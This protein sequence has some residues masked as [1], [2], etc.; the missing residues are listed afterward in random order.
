[1]AANDSVGGPVPGRGGKAGAVPPPQ[2]NLKAA[3]DRAVEALR[4][5]SPEQMLWLGAAG[6]PDA[7]RLPVLDD[8][9][10][11]DIDGGAVRTSGG[12]DVGA[13]WR[14]LVL[15]YL[16]ISTRPQPRQPETTF[17]ALPDAMTYAGVYD[18][19][20]I[21]RL[22]ATAGRDA[23]S[24]RA[25]AD[26]LAAVPAT[27]GDLLGARPAAGG[28]LAMDFA[29]FPRLTL[30]LVWYAGDD[31]FEPSAAILLPGN[32]RMMFCVEDI[33]VL[34]EC[35]VSRLSGRPF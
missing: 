12:G 13:Q 17:A 26:L 9:L 7:W 18:A 31:E 3:T 10:R 5:R 25:A 34:S 30:R 19:R 24:L 8:V 23:D 21:R 2:Q 22:C 33:V 29:V 28:D 11:V 35:M 15:H 1:M 14:I 6:G 16:A 32:I 20:V 4:G 27:G